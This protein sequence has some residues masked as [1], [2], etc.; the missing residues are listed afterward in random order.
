LAAQGDIKRTKTY[1]GCTKKLIG[2]FRKGFKWQNIVQKMDIFAKMIYS[3]F[4]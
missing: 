3:Y 1:T 2:P 4:N